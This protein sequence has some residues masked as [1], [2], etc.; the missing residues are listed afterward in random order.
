MK[1]LQILQT[2]K[3]PILILLVV[4]VLSLFVL[5]TPG[6]TP[7]NNQSS[8]SAVRAQ[9][10]IK[11]IS[12]EPHSYYEREAHE[13]VRQY[14]LTTLTDYLGASNVLEYNYT[15]NEVKAELNANYAGSGVDGV[16]YPIENVVGIL[17]GTNPE[18]IML[19]S[20]YDSRGHVG[21]TGEQGRS[22]GAMDDGYGVS[23]M[24]ELAYLL[25]DTNPTNSVYFL[26]TDAEEVG[27]YGAIMAAA[28][29]SLMANIRFVINL[30]SRGSTG[31]AY[32][33]ETSANNHK[34]IDLYRKANFPVTYS[35][36]TAV[37]ELMPN[38][39]DFTPLMETGLPCLNFAVLAG[40]DHYHTPLDRYEDI[41]ITSVQHMGS[42]VE[43]VVREFIS[44]AKYIED[45]YFDAS[46]NQ[47]FFT[48]FAGVMIN[49]S[50]VFA[51]I[52]AVLILVLFGLVTFLKVKDKTLTKELF[53]KTLPKGLLLFVVMAVVGILYGYVVAFLGK[54]P[55]SIT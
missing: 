1:N 49:Y 22:Y 44:D 13:D 5:Y 14:L 32:M 16:I 8:F 33:F 11:E 10:H 7:S 46:S 25:K 37:Y 55:F 41:D 39:T 3:L 29:T 19:V 12:R 15:I 38:Y 28:D 51:V 34:V 36:A 27:L 40:L 31:P 30:E 20:H 50:Y 24:L 9:E 48:I 26:F 2:K 45:G 35:M 43:P 54:V 17:P 6:A 4:L 42:Q 53:T 52:L 47:V 23:T 18:G 21:R